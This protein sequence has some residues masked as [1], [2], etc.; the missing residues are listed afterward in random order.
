VGPS[1]LF[2]ALPPVVSSEHTYALAA[3]LLLGRR[4]VRPTWTVVGTSTHRTHQMLDDHGS[5]LL[6]MFEFSI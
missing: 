5:F 1:A 3:S 6:A 4:G 2:L